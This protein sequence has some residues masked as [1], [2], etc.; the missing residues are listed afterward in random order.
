[1]GKNWEKVEIK[2]RPFFPR[3]S[4]DFLQ[5]PVFNVFLFFPN[6]LEIFC[7]VLFFLCFPV[8]PIL[9]EGHS[10]VFQC[11]P[12]FYYFGVTQDVLLLNDVRL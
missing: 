7:D 3:F 5:F 11:F 1:M 9:E 4:R 2:I 6:F 10:Y 8:F 12:M